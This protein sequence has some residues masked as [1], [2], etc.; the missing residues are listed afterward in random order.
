MHICLPNVLGEE[1]TNIKANFKKYNPYKGSGGSLTRNLRLV[2][3]PFFDVRS[4]R[5]G[6]T[7][8]EGRRHG[9]TGIDRVSTLPA[10]LSSTRNVISDGGGV[11][12][13]FDWGTPEEYGI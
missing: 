9:K 8:V 11:E 2:F 5:K 1:D 3:F 6:R 10:S 4:H 7:E 12:I 13:K